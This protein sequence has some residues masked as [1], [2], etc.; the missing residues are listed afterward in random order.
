MRI[1]LNGEPV[2]VEDQ[3][4]NQIL[5]ACGYRDARVATAVNGVVVHRQARHETRLRDGD[6]LEVIAPI[7]GG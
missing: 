5:D 7:F 3:P 6:Q 4:L 1:E 2:E